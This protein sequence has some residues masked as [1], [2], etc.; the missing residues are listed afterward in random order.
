MI[1][2]LKIDCE[3]CEYELLEKGVDVFRSHV[4]YVVMEY[5]EGITGRD[6]QQAIVKPLED[7]DFTV[8]VRRH[9]RGDIGFV[10]G[11]NQIGLQD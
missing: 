4:R 5:H 7:Q 8:D 10:V 11:V 1:D 9:P 3:G 2:F 6:V